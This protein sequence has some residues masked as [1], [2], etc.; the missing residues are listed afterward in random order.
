MRELELARLEF[1]RDVT[2][3]D[4]AD[5]PVEPDIAQA[6]ALLAWAEHLVLVYPTWW[7]TMPALLKAFLDRVLAPGFAFADE[8]KSFVPLL[9]GR[10]AELLTT[11]DTPGWVWRWIYGAP[12]DRALARATLGFC[13]IK[14]ARIARC[15]PI[16]DSS[17]AQRQTW[18]AAA[19]R[20]GEALRDGP[21]SPAQR[22]RGKLAS[23][24]KALR[25]QF[26]PMTWLAYVVGALAAAGG[27]GLRPAPFWLGL[28]CLFLLEVAT[29]FSNE[30]VDY[31]SDRRNRNHGPFTGGS[32]VLVTGELGFGEVRRGIALALGLA[33]LCALWLIAS[34]GGA[35]AA[36]GALLA[37]MAL[38]A[39]GYTLPP[40]KLSYRGLGELDVGLTHSL[41]AILCGFVFQG[42]AWHAPLPWLLSLPLALA[43][44][45][46]ITLS[47]V[48]DLA[49]DAAVGK[50]TLAVRTGVRGAYAI[51]ALCTLLAAGTALALQPLPALAG[52]LAGI[53]YGVLPH[54]LLLLTMLTAY[55]RR[56]RDPR[57]IDALMALA[58]SYIMWFVGI[59]FAHALARL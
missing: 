36:A 35:A 42:G 2:T 15:G 52:L 7:G 48:P 39:L 21:L 27:E 26:Y 47:G 13:G 25:L 29:V 30:V 54:A 38:L 3:R 32:R 6:R 22:L 45:P 37:A 31:E 23:W 46:A 50:R 4:F 12:G 20:R 34:T 58:L 19:E 43:I 24:L 14:V 11:M 5:Q 9:G 33:L 55:S 57:R 16:K 17:A 10:S 28:A 49:A 53:E 1:A 59:P 40:L 44:L 51:A 56:H 41:G 8:G 18:L